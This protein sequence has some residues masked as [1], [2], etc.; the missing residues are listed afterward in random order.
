MLTCKSGRF[1]EFGIR[2]VICNQLGGKVCGFFF[3]TKAFSPVTAITFQHLQ[4]FLDIVGETLAVSRGWFPDNQTFPL[5][6][7]HLPLLP[8]RGKPC[9]Y[10]HFLMFAMFP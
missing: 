3:C 10:K 2:F 9:H 4:H 8:D 1:F 5:A 6:D 7:E